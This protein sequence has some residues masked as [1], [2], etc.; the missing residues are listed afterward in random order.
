MNGTLVLPDPRAFTWSPNPKL[1]RSIDPQV[2]FC[3]TMQTIKYLA[4]C[5]NKLYIYPELNQ[6]GRIHYHG[7]L[8]I[9]DKVKWY[10][11]VLPKFKYTGFVMIKTEINE[12]WDEYIKKDSAMMEEILE[13]KLPIIFEKEIDKTWLQS[14]NNK[15]F[16]EKYKKKILDN[17]QTI[18]AYFEG[19]QKRHPDISIANSI[20]EA[21]EIGGSL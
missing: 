6:N 1:F 21:N 4:N 8:Y 9:T 5:C 19:S 11:S 7:V 12:H 20:Y 16:K 3:E 17:P 2:Q 15:V 10:K 13:Y 18:Q 14:R